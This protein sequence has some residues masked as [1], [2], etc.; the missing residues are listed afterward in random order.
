MAEQPIGNGRAMS[1]L[2]ARH[3]ARVVVA[4]QNETTATAT[5]EQIKAEG[6]D[7]A[8]VV[9]DVSD[10]NSVEDM[11]RQSR[12]WLG[13]IDG[14]AYNVGI[15]GAVGFDQ[16]SPESWDA[17]LAVNLRGAM[18]TARA[19]L[20]DMP[21]GSSWVFTSAVAALKPTGQLIAYETSKA[22][23]SGLMRAVAFEGKSR[24]IRANI[25]LLGNIATGMHLNHF[26]DGPPL[27]PV[28]L[29]RD[30]TAW[31]VAYAALFFLSNE[32]TFIT[33]QT[34]AVDGG[35]TSLR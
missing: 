16:T 8:V 10:P 26:R 9:A 30:G 7:A 21:S 11:I 3:G 20:S 25:V 29:G 17:T 5:V 33:G 27:I 24:A 18:L 28:P 1:V 23:L 19:A 22:A 4:D 32:S 31:E 6:G 15:T 2:M 14:I 13:G 34:L 12:A 35:R